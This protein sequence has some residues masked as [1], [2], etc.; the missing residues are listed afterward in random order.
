MKM[1]SVF[2][3]FLIAAFVLPDM[4]KAYVLLPSETD[5]LSWHQATVL[6]VFAS[7]HKARYVKVEVASPREKLPIHIWRTEKKAKGLVMLIPGTGAN[8]NSS[9]A[10]IVA[11][12]LASEGFDTVIVADPFSPDFQRSFSKDRAV[13]FPHNDSP[14]TITMLEQSYLEYVKR[15]GTPA[16]IHLMGISLGGMYA[17]RLASMKS[18]L[19]FDRFIAINPP[20]DLGYAIE[21][22][23]QSIRVRLDT[24]QFSLREVVINNLLPVADMTWIRGL[25]LTEQTILEAKALLSDSEETNMGLIGASFQIDL[26]AITLGLRKSSAYT[27]NYQKRRLERQLT[28]MTFTKYMGL[29][30][31]AIDPKGVQGRRFVDLMNDADLRLAI[32]A[33][34]NRDKL[35]MITSND[36]FLLQ[37][38]DLS[39]IYGLLGSRLQVLKSG[40]H[41]GEL[42]TEGFK[43]ALK[44][45]LK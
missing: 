27:E 12:L 31:A 5:T 6:S 17:H 40:G 16:K 3:L 1:R 20:V 4:A 15:H 13:G 24:A 32:E 42:W 10:A 25:K 11:D 39:D 19:K 18:K 43:A 33:A 34:P 9:Q 36:D 23:D 41:C 28:S 2:K 7:P 22:I 21:K 45:T 35:Y 26:I 44:T 8:S 38:G 37:P 14:Q 30:S 29:A